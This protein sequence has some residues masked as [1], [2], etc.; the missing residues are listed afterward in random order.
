MLDAPAIARLEDRVTRNLELLGGG[1]VVNLIGS[2]TTESGLKVYPKIDDTGYEKGRKVPDAE[3]ANVNLQ[4]SRFH[5][6]WNYVIRP[7]E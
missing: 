5:G 1:I 7:N 6:E 2:T 4:P 3:L